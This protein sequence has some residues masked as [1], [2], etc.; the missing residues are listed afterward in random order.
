MTKCKHCNEDLRFDVEQIGIDANKLPVYHRFGYCDNCKLKYDLDAQQPTK[1]EDDKNKKNTVLGTI[2]LVMSLFGC[3]CFIGGILALIDIGIGGKDRK[4]TNAWAALIIG[5]IWIAFGGMFG[6]GTSI[7]NFL[8]GGGE[9]TNTVYNVG[10]TIDNDGLKIQ[11][12]SA[13]LDFKEY[14]SYY[15]PNDGYKYIK[16]DLY[17][18][19][20]SKSEKFVGTTEFTCYADGTLQEE[21]Y[22]VDN[23]NFGSV[24]LASGKNYSFSVCYKVPINANEIELEYREFIGSKKATIKLK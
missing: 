9:E 24:N 13:D 5:V 7:N 21:T 1:K 11:I 14:D 8:T 19:N 16:I 23:V 20:D 22:I 2:A 18:V 3:T 4:H 15:T 12:K 10:D 6:L 17:C